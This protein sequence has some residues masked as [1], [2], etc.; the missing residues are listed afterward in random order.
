MS[1]QMLLFGTLPLEGVRLTVS[2][3]FEIV[4][5]H[6]FAGKPSAG[7]FNSNRKAICKSIG[8]IHY[9]V[10]L[11]SDVIRHLNHREAKGI[12]PQ[13][14]KHDI[15]LL[16]ILWNLARKWK[17]RR[18]VM[19][20]I[21]MAKIQ[22]PE[23]NPVIDIKRPK[24]KPRKKVVTPDEWAKW[25]EHCTERLKINSHYALFTGMSPID[26]KKLR[27]SQYN[28]YSDCLDVQRNKTGEVESIPVPDFIRQHI[29]EAIRQKREFLLDFRNHN[30]E[31]KKV[32]RA[33]GVHFWFGRDLR[34]T[35]A[36]EIW[37]RT[38]NPRAVQKFL[39]HADQR[40]SM[41]HYVIDTGGELRPHIQEMEKE[42][43]S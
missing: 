38:K 33:S 36:N 8:H 19:D 13:T 28:P 26:L 40:T 18:S 24:T 1:E 3:W 32:R 23:E 6:H 7:P 31:I 22:L 4:W 15:K 2:E 21:D 10:L 41:T 42:F 43:S 16:T 30:K 12:G 37:K 29:L 14:R 39:L 5:R 11:E 34:K 25:I 20:G 17:R 9:N 27:T 35:G